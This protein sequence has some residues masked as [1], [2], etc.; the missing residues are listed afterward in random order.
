M[1]GRLARTGGPKRRTGLKPGGRLARRAR[2]RSRSAKTAR[3]Y[4]QE[5]R[6][7][8]AGMLTERPWCE[9]RWDSR[10]QG[11]SVDVHEI[12][13]RGRGGSITDEANC[14][15]GC[16]YCHDQIDDHPQE[17]EDRGFLA[18]SGRPRKATR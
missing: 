7:L 4:E 2:L 3:V 6:P 14:V 13:S 9:I 5:R 8:V 12:L 11:R 15:T 17:A 18:P 1:T 10:C 16:R